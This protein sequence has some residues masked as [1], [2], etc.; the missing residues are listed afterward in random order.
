ML[1][2]QDLPARGVPA[3]RPVIIDLFCGEGGAGRGYAD[4]G[5]RVLGVDQDRR[6]LARYPFPSFCG[7]WEDGLSEWLGVLRLSDIA[8][9]HASPPCQHYSVAVMEKD[10]HPDLIPVVRQT[11]SSLRLPYIIENVPGAPLEDPLELC[12]CMF[13]L[14]TRLRGKTFMLYR[15]RLFECGGFQPAAP[16]H[17]P[18]NHIL[19]AIPV[20]GHGVP[21]W[22][23][24]QHGFGPSAAERARLMGVPWMSRE[25][26]A[27]SIP[28]AFTK[29]LAQFLDNAPDHM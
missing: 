25:G 28:P 26:L 5:F 11:L 1:R 14:T 20:M 3:V 27:E 19:P 18:Q 8:A 16:Q 15:P 2:G 17:L 12:G 24:K 23:Y 10:R 29:Y 9:V 4:A 21:G 13:G 22:F 7:S 6:A